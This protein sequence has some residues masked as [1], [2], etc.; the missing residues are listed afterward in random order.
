MIIDVDREMDPEKRAS[1]S[2][3][4]DKILSQEAYYDSAL[5]Y[6]VLVYGGQPWLK[7]VILPTNGTYAVHAWMHE[8]YWTTK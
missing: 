7:G 1:I 8:R 6:T 5:E 4:I 2:R 3:E